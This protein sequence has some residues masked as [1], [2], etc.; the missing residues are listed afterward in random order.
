MREELI[1]LREKMAEA[2]IDVYLIVSDDYHMSEYVGEYFKCREYVSG[3]DGSAGSLVITKT[4]AGLWTDGRYFL[5]A[6]EQLK[7]S[8]IDLYR[9]GEENVPTI[10]EFLTDK[11][12]PQEV[13]GFDGRTVSIRMATQFIRELKEQGVSVRPDLDLAGAIW[14]NRPKISAE[15]VWFLADEY[16]GESREE[17]IVKVR[18]KMQEL[19]ADYFLI[20]SLDEIAWILN[21][22]GNDVAYNPVVLSYLLIGPETICWYVDSSAVSEEKRTVL[23]QMGIICRNYMDIYQDLRNLSEEDSIL[24]DENITNYALYD[25]IPRGMHLC[26]KASPIEL[27]K[28]VKNRMEMQNVRKAHLKDGVALTRLIYWLKHIPDKKTVTELDVCRRLEEFRQEGTHYLGQSFA[29][30]A[31]YGAH[32]AI[33]HYEPTE[34]TNS[35][36]DNKGFLLLDTGGQYLY[37]TTDVT[38]TIALGV[39]TEEEKLHYTAVLRGNL[40]LAAARFKHGC[41]GMN[42]DY[43]AREP[44]WQMGLDYNHGTGHG[45]GYLLNVHEGPNAIRHRERDGRGT[46]L[47]EGMITSDEPGLY[48]AGQYGIRLENLILC[49]EE[50]KNSYGTFMR[51]E[52][53]TL[54][55]FDMDAVCFEALSDRE[56]RL[57]REYQQNVYT[58]LAEYLPS[59]EREWLKEQVR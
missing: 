58:A 18:G 4:E 41:T 1:Q 53:L 17:K 11:M 42:L 59:A 29:P 20:P 28:A 36:L 46:V 21:V 3:F 39:L 9:S 34:E 50:K 33:V 47:E 30:I 5:Q 40:N 24:I 2:G 23:E 51:F 10:L 14:E 55:P 13:F 19:K 44:L 25:A 32:G 38:R 6:G 27:M 48:L 16:A 8:G 7:G 45:V 22:R 43:A 31:A 15:P 26:K 52:T 37:G 49:T 35:S 54:V 57:L 56:K 12:N